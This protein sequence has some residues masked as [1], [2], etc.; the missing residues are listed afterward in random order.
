MSNSIIR[1]ELEGKLKTW[2][3]AQVPRVPIA[4][5]GVSFTKPT[6]GA[7]LEPLLIPN[8]TADNLAGSRKTS[9]G[10]FEV[11]C[12]YPSGKG[13]GGVEQLTNSIINL[14]PLLP[15]TGVVSIENT[16][17]AEHPQIDEAGWLIVPVLVFYRYES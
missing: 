12:W 17:Y 9:L 15:K 1:A 13:M 8:V 10:I 4:F 6:T 7:F 11:R 2:A 14:F 5:E 16:P 3:D